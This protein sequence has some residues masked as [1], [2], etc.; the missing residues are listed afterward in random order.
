M[1]PLQP[2]PEFDT[3]SRNWVLHVVQEHEVGFPDI[4]AVTYYG[5]GSE[6]LWWVICLVNGVVDP[7]L[8][9][10]P[11]QRLLIPP[12]DLVARYATRRTRAG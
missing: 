12:R 6:P 7:D 2:P 8:D 10:I 5:K 3:P 9:I 11:G 1:G 4:L